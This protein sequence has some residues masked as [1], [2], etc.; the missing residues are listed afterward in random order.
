MLLPTTII[1]GPLRQARPHRHV[2]AATVDL[3]AKPLRCCSCGH[4]Q[5][6]APETTAARRRASITHIR[7]SLIG[8]MS[9]KPW[10]QFITPRPSDA[11]QHVPAPLLAALIL[12]GE[13][14]NFPAGAVRSGTGGPTCTSKHYRLKSKRSC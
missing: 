5:L 7:V 14:S 11:L 6:F 13:E 4:H 9:S 12:T 2:T 10:H 3:A 1:G 8:R